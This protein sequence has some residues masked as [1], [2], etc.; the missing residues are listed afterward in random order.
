V[1]R[2]TVPSSNEHG[3]VSIL[4]ALLM[5]A[6]LGFAALAVDVGLL[7]SEK[8]QLQNGADA[9]ALGIAQTCAESPGSTLCS[10][11]SAVATELVNKNSLDSLG[12][13]HSI[14]LSANRVTVT[15]S[16]KEEG[17]SDHRVSLFFAQALGIPSAEVS[18]RSGARWGSPIS[19]TAPFPLVFS[20][21]QVQGQIDGAMQLLQ[22]HGKNENA[23]CNYGPSGAA[24][25]GGFGW[26]AQT[27]GQCGAFIDLATNTGGS[28]TGN[29]GPSNCDSL[30][31]SWGADITAGKKVTL[32][33]PVFDSTTGTGSGAS[34]HLVYFAAYEVAGWSFKGGSSL[35]D[36][37]RNKPAD[38]GALACT[39][40]CR[41]I[42]GKFIKYV[43]LADGYDLGPVDS[44][45][46]T[47]VHLT[48]GDSSP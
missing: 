20:I 6:F 42:I 25:P 23:D 16:S 28:D 33:I 3:A 37:F 44:S 48:L 29:D 46:L 22:S 12:N 40:N 8:A 47:N 27:A 9:A 21:C 10:S 15:T 7:Y 2:L 32:L 17:R 36:S 19:G 45:G 24:V 43:S 35:P 26:L 13:V 30:L 31:N 5:V 4:V 11:S 38:A 34:Y 18:A 39:G 1:R 14:V 41:G